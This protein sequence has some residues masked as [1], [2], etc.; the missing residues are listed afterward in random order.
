[1]DLPK[2]VYVDLLLANEKPKRIEGILQEQFFERSLVP[3]M[4][5]GTSFSFGWARTG[6]Q[7][8]PTTWWKII[9]SDNPHDDSLANAKFIEFLTQTCGE[10]V[11]EVHA[12]LKA[13]SEKTV[14][15]DVN[16]LEYRDGQISPSKAYQDKV[17]FRLKKKGWVNRNYTESKI[18]RDNEAYRKH[19]EALSEQE[20]NR[21]LVTRI[22]LN[23]GLGYPVDIDVVFS[24]N[25]AFGVVEYKRKDPMYGHFPFIQH[26]SE[27]ESFLRLLQK[28]FRD[29][30]SEQDPLKG[31]NE[32]ELDYETARE[33]LWSFIKDDDR[34]I[35]VSEYIEEPCFGLDLSHLK[36]AEF[37]RTHGL[38][39]RYLIW[40]H[41][42]PKPGKSLLSTKLIPHLPDEKVLFQTYKNRALVVEGLNLTIGIDSGSFTEDPESEEAR[43]QRLKLYKSIRLQATFRSCECGFRAVDRFRN[44][45]ED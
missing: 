16:V 15:L 33:Y 14:G 7:W 35:N 22:L 30:L 1:M 38:H 31:Q 11:I 9:D 3:R 21:L 8:E 20:L 23:N 36:T 42:S 44:F 6:G 10:K 19:F 43:E 32:P 34:W 29:Y 5:E 17:E 12:C 28:D 39:Y 37:C 40:N 25:E 41:A 4:K 27:T 45:L 24:R 13:K 26:R 18:P 2:S